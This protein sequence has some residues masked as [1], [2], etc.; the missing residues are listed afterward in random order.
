MG[1]VN[2]CALGNPWKKAS[3]KW[4]VTERDREGGKPTDSEAV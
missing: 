1:A 4:A 2:D 3:V